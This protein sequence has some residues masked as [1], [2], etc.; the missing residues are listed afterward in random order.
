MKLILLALAIWLLISF[1]MGVFAGRFIKGV[2][3]RHLPRTRAQLSDSMGTNGGAAE[4]ENVQTPL[5]DIMSSPPRGEERFLSDLQWLI[6][7]YEGQLKELEAHT[8]DVRHKLEIAVEASR[9][10]EEE[11]FSEDCP[12]SLRGKKV[13]L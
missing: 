13:F 8:A 2:R 11:E 6:E 10:L 9:L 7:R 12:S 5:E 1:P 3:R 4:Q